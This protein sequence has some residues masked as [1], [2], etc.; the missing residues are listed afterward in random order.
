MDSVVKT[1]DVEVPVNTAY[2]QWT[3]FES[4]PQFM[5]GVEEVHQL[6]ETHLH[7]KAKIGGK[8]KEWDAE[9]SEQTPDQRVAWYAENG[10]YNAGVVTFH[11]LAEGKR[12]RYAA[13]ITSC[14][15]GGA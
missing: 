15:R 2:N 4:F 6:D 14:D 12:K 13:V 3:Q 11:H 8:A 9:I 1:I 7:W 5:D 10:T